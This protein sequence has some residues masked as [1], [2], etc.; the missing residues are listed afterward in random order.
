MNRNMS[1]GLLVFVCGLSLLG[2][3]ACNGNGGGEQDRHGAIAYGVNLNAGLATGNS[4]LSAGTAAV[5]HCRSAGGINCRVVLMF[6]NACGAS[7]HSADGTR[8]GVGWDTSKANAETKAIA[9]CHAA[10]GEAC[11]IITGTNRR[12]SF[13]ATGGPSP[14]IG[15]ASAI[16]PQSPNDMRIVRGDPAPTPPAPTPPSPTVQDSW[17]A[18]ATSSDPRSY[19]I[20]IGYRSESLA[21]SAALS[22]C[23]RTTTTCSAT[24]RHGGT[25]KNSCGAVAWDITPGSQI[26]AWGGGYRTLS[27]ASDAAL[28]TC[29]GFGGRNCH[30]ATN[31]NGRAASGCTSNVR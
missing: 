14:A 26:H 12:F 29:R 17:G 28:S 15:E 6:R 11:R 5:N 18:I 23:G 30:I 13:C 3:A 25:F 1:K 16:P 19:G 2:L 10:G 7:A 31:A 20:A 22:F 8:A 24:G 4:Q 21:R 9:A 27:E